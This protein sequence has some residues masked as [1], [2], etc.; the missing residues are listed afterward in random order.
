[1]T[2]ISNA[3]THE[4]PVLSF[5]SEISDEIRHPTHMATWGIPLFFHEL[6]RMILRK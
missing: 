4:R 2:L 5:D 6:V 3:G 1:M